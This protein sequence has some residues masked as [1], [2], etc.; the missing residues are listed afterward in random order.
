MPS[1][2]PVPTDDAPQA[3]DTPALFPCPFCGSASVAMDRFGGTGPGYGV[4]CENPACGAIG[5]CENATAEAA[6]AVWNRANR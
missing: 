1:D 2:N 6:A 5:P 3:T 4:S